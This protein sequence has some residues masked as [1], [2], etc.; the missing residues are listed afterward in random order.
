MGGFI[1]GFLALEGACLGKELFFKERKKKKKK[2][3]EE[4]EET[5]F[6][7]RVAAGC[8]LRG[9]TRWRHWRWRRRR[10]G[11]RQAEHCARLL[12][13]GVAYV[14]KTPLFSLLLCVC[15]EPVLV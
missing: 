12:V 1:S 6:L 11:S 7:P 9:G 4:E 5:V 14:R 13:K 8:T 15:P 3:E 2:K 10:V